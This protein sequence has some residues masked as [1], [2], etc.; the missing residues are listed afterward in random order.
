MERTQ[1]F[2]KQLLGERHVASGAR[3]RGLRLERRSDRKRVLVAAS[4]LDGFL[5]E[6]HGRSNR[7]ARERGYA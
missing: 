3:E 7:L 6:R 4:D 2:V 5:D 1:S